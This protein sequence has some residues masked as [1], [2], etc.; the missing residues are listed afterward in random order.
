MFMRFK[1]GLR[2]LYNLTQ[3]RFYRNFHF[4]IHQFKIHD[5]DEVV[6]E[7][8]L[9]NDDDDD[10]DSGAKKKKSKQK[11]KKKG[12][13]TEGKLWDRSCLIWSRLFSR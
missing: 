7:N 9:V 8:G 10:D 5:A 11:V 2:L 4:K 3:A 1:G 13:K 12:E 6:P